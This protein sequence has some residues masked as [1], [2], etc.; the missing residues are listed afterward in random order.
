MRI[1]SLSPEGSASL[2]MQVLFEKLP[3]FCD[4]CGLMG[5]VI[6]ECGTYECSEDQIQY[7]D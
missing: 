3:K 1:V 7:G 2:F 5:H 4:H 6:L